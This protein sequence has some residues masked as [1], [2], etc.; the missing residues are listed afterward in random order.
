ME[1]AV[2]GYKVQAVGHESS[3]EITV[4]DAS[5]TTVEV[6]DLRP[7]T[8]YTFNISAITKAGTGP[9]ATIL[10]KTP[11]GGEA[12]ALNPDTMVMS[13]YLLML[14]ASQ[15]YSLSLFPPSLSA[16]THVSMGKPYVC[17]VFC[18]CAT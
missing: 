12:P 18:P 1:C 4:Q 10:F 6:S 11:E 5:T 7:F 17:N 16:D 9:A 15:L 8:S 3:Q 14:T 13:I 2:I